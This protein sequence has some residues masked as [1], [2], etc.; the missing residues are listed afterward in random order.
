MDLESTPAMGELRLRLADSQRRTL[1]SARIAALPRVEAVPA[2]ELRSGKWR[3][4]S[5]RLSAL[6]RSLRFQTPL[7]RINVEFGRGRCDVNSWSS[8]IELMAGEVASLRKEIK[9]QAR[10]LLDPSLV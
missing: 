7:D 5:R 4:N 1:L 9:V 8:T 3:I 10:K 2:F 6:R